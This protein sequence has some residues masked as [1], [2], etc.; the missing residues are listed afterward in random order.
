MNFNIPTPIQ[1]MS[2]PVALEEKIFR[3]CTNRTGKTLAFAIPL[4]NKLVLDKNALALVMCPTR[5]WPLK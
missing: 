4:I 5:D 2:I 1:S 3:N